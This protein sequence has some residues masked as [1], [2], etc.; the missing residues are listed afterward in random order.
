LRA[1]LLG[2]GTLLLRH[3]LER[4]VRPQALAFPVRLD[5]S[6]EFIDTLAKK[7]P[8][9]ASRAVVEL[10]L[11]TTSLLHYLNVTTWVVVTF[12]MPSMKPNG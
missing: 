6:L 8:K 5:L 11:S 2:L 12:V 3:P 7:A 10:E 9:A 1:L 4:F